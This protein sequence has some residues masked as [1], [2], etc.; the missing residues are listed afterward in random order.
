MKLRRKEYCSNS[1][2]RCI[3]G[4]H[5]DPS[6]LLLLGRASLPF[7]WNSI[8]RIEDVHHCLFGHWCQRNGSIY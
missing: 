6:A 1:F 3:F 7:S 4:H 5:L 8:G 2:G